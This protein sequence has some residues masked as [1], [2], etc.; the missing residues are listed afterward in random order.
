MLKATTASRE[1]QRQA[2]IRGIDFCSRILFILHHRRDELV[3]RIGEDRV[4]ETEQAAGELLQLGAELLQ[5]LPPDHRDKLFT[6]A[7][8]LYETLSGGPDGSADASPS[9]SHD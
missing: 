8:D 1:E 7:K 5:D 4:N 2:I 9:D 6:E 3:A